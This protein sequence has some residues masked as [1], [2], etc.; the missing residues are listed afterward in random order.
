MKNYV[1]IIK[2]PVRR[3][4]NPLKSPVSA[5]ASRIM[6]DG[7]VELRLGVK[8]KALYCYT[9]V[10]NDT[11]KA[12]AERILRNSGYIFNSFINPPE[13]PSAHIPLIRK[14]ETRNKITPG[15]P[16]VQKFTV[17]PLTA[18][19]IRIESIFSALCEMKSHCGISV[20]ITKNYGLDIASYNRLF[21]DELPFF[22]ENVLKNLSKA[23]ERFEVSINLYGEDPAEIRLLLSEIVF[24]FP[25]L[26]CPK[27]SSSPLPANLKSIENLYTQEE[28]DFLTLIGSS[29][30][31]FGLPLN[32]DTLF[33]LPIETGLKDGNPN[34]I[35]GYSE[36]NEPFTIPLKMLRKHIFIS[37]EP[38]SGKGNEI[39]FITQQ[40]HLNKIPF[41]MIESAKKEQ[42][43]LAKVMPLKVWRPKES[44][45]IYNPFQLPPKVTLRDYRSSLLQTIR[46]C[47]KL[48]GP[49]E[50]LFDRALSNCFVRYGYNDDSFITEDDTFRF[51][52]SEFIEEY[53]SLLSNQSY[54]EKTKLDMTT[55]GQVRLNTLFNENRGVFDTV[56]SIPVNEL[57][58]GENLLQL[59]CLPTLKSKQL[60]STM[61][62]ICLSAY[63]RLTYNTLS[64]SPLKLVIILDESHNL[65]KAVNNNASGEEYGFASEFYNLLLELR[66]LG[67]GI[68]MADQSVNNIPACLSEVC[69]TKLFFGCSPFFSGLEKHKE[70]FNADEVAFNHMHLISPG[71]AVV[72]TYGMAKGAFIRTPNV[73][74]KFKLNEEYSPKNSFTENN[75]RLIETFKE[76]EKCPS[77]NKCTVTL[78]ASARQKAENLLL[79]F[80][81]ELRKNFSDKEKLNQ[82]M[83]DVAANAY[84]DALN[85]IERAC[86][87][88]QF[89]RDFNRTS[90]KKLDIDVVLKLSE[91]IWDKIKEKENV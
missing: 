74:D 5:L 16:P 91:H 77:R 59:N 36:L 53:T 67:V 9:V 1:E 24:A 78:K 42:H 49:L 65:L 88:V 52:L 60:F 29:P 25:G 43:H 84:K 31:K 26:T 63:I 56:N 72:T 68:I 82:I 21:L 81:P 23:S 76:C 54:S 71:E 4:S 38:G 55:A 89:L 28:T 86:I 18:D 30:E 22:E 20:K 73:I 10:D 40:L 47:F 90:K 62:L 46:V 69:A 58:K 48:D 80:A 3:E 14:V 61:L 6:K 37:G 12:Q 8:N 19:P 35:L 64:D 75:R 57:I 66:S 51:G 7:T 39:F 15:S 87:M 33:G 70:F 45:F 32:K 11:L 83:I 17:S 27:E 2:V 79:I 34:I 44:E 85:P 13:F 50:E 41:L